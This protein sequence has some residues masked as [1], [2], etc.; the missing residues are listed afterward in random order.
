ME[1]FDF[2]NKEIWQKRC[3]WI[4]NEIESNMTG[5]SYLVSDH[6]T[7][8]FA[9]LQASYCIG[10]WLLVIVLSVSII[11][12]HL[13]E[14]EAINDKIETAKLLNDYYEGPFDINWLRR[15]RNKY[16]HVDVD[17]PA[18]KMNHQYEKR[19]EMEQDAT[20]AVKMIIKAF[21]QSPGT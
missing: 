6:A 19:E 20:K 14:T 4:E 9:D 18:L 21:F 1:L 2:P 5:G 16:V 13:R 10:A 15:L 17:N 8:L 12:A 7:A 3:D 11:D